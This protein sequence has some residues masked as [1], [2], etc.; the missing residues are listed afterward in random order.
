MAWAMCKDIIGRLHLRRIAINIQ[1]RLCV[2]LGVNVA[3]A[4]N[5]VFIVQQVSSMPE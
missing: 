3:L 1:H 4:I 5:I 2:C